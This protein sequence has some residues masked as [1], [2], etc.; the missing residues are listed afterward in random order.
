M[1]LIESSFTHNLVTVCGK[2]RK[3]L[4]IE[5][6]SLCRLQDTVH[7]ND[8][9]DAQEWSYLYFGRFDRETSCLTQ[10]TSAAFDSAVFAPKVEEGGKDEEGSSG[11]KLVES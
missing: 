10:L 5:W 3:L 8:G 4:N 1:R 11:A 2:I 6:V 9:I 7:G